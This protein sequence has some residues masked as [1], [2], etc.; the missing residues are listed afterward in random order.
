VGNSI[1][2][3]RRGHVVHLK[4]NNPTQTVLDYLRLDEKSKGTK[5]G[6]NEGDCGACTVAIGRIKNNKLVYEPANACILFVGHLHGCELV[7]VDDLAKGGVLH[8]V[9]DAM[10]KHHASQ[11]GFCT[12]GFVMSLFTLYQSGTRPTR[13]DIVDYIAGNLCRCTGYRPIIDAALEACNGKPL[14]DWAKNEADTVTALQALN[15]GQDVM[16]ETSAGFLAIPASAASLTRLA[17]QYPEATI[18]SGATDVGLWVNKQMR[19]LPKLIHTFA[20]D[21]LHDIKST[22]AAIEIGAAAT[23][24]EAYETL[25]M[26]SPD[27]AEVLRRLGSKHVRATGTIGGNIANGS[28]IGDMPPMLIALGATLT[29]RSGE[30]SRSMEL[31]KFFIKYGAQDR[32]PGELVWQI[33]VPKLKPN[34]IFKAFKISKRFDQDISAVLFALKITKAGNSVTSARLAMGGMAATPKRGYKTEQ[35]LTHIDLSDETS[36]AAAIKSLD[37]DFQ[38]ISDMRASADYRMRTAQALLQKALLEVAGLAGDTRVLECLEA[39]E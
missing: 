2:F 32:N 28:P 37:E 12:P 25:A 18:V 39:A 3:L 16:I 10:I 30:T 35:A 13:Q 15:D 31:E 6:C 20:V 26:L 17:S 34:E 9:Q 36:W 23:Y 8:P 24:A 14:D 5:E 19:T 1:A 29:L 38:P 27:V 22:L 21:E 33:L 7:T 4:P 11:C